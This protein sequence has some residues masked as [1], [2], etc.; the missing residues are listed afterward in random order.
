[1]REYI[2]IFTMVIF[3]I[4]IIIPVILILWGVLDSQYKSRYMYKYK[5]QNCYFYMNEELIPIHSITIHKTKN[6]FADIP[7]LK[8][9]IY[10][11]EKEKF[12][13]PRDMRGDMK[14]LSFSRRGLHRDL[15]ATVKR[16]TCIIIHY[17]NG[18][19]AIA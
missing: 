16:C 15:I 5:P 7:I 6:E 14:I 19:S 8:D 17:G 3:A 1:M 11:K 9:T 10:V 2:C 18:K 13:V 4:I 12:T